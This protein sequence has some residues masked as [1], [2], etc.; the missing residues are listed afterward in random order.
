ML[1]PSGPASHSVLVAA[2]RPPRRSRLRHDAEC[3]DPWCLGMYLVGQTVAMGTPYTENYF[4]HKD[5]RYLCSCTARW[6]EV[7]GRVRRASR[8][9][10][11]AG[12]THASPEGGRRS[13]M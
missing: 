4:V 12:S 10:A 8:G 13:E 6:R 5:H 2:S 11:T 7:Y 9:D 3:P 1:G